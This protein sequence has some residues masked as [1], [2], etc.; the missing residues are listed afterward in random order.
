MG[1]PNS[2]PNQKHRKK[3]KQSYKT[4]NVGAHTGLM[5]KIRLLL[6]SHSDFLLQS[7]DSAPKRPRGHS[8]FPKPR[9]YWRAAVCCAN[10]LKKIVIFCYINEMLERAMI[11]CHRITIFLKNRCIYRAIISP[12]SKNRDFMI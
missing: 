4:Q 11:F 10:E 5:E 8:K 7:A 2:K 1:Y 3:P 12:V 9:R 6:S